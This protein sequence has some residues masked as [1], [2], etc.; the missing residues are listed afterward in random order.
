MA[1]ATGK[2]RCMICQKD[3]ATMR[4]G[5]CLQE[6]CYKHMENHRQELNKQLDEIEINRDLFR[7][8]LTQHT[9]QSNYHLLIQQINH[10]EQNSMKIIQ[11]TADEAR[12]ILIQNTNKYISQLE[13]KLNQLTDQLRESREENDFNEINLRLFQEELNKLTQELIKPSNILIQED[14]TSFINKISV[15]VSGNCTNSILDGEI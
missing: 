7:H 4:C 8:S 10:W 2:T 1:T 14:S 11:Q 15:H 3:K 6:Y 12:E 5:G 9:E 13:I